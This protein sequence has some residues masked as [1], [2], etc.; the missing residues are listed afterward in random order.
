MTIATEILTVGDELLRGDVVDENSA[1]LATRL[2]QLGLAV[3]RC[4]SV[5]DPLEPLVRQLERA[6]GRCQL[7][8]VTGG[9]GPTD[10]DR[11]TEAV[12]R[13]GGLE[14]QLRE[15]VLEA[16]RERF[17]RAGYTLTANNEKQAWI[18][19]GATLL[20][21]S[22]GTAPGYM[23]RHGQ[24][25][26]VCLPGVPMELKKIF[27][28]HVAPLL[29]QQL[30][31]RP[32]L[33]RSLNTFG[34]GESQLDH[35]L[36]RLLDEVDHGDCEVSVHYRTSFPCNHLILVVRPAE[37]APAQAAS[38]V[39][40]RLEAAAREQVGKY[41]YGVDDTSFSDAVVAALREHGATLA[42][43]ESCTG[44]L[45]GDLITS[46]SGSSEVFELG[47]ITYSNEVK[48]KLLGVE[49]QIFEDHGA[50][51]QQCVEA[52]ARGVRRLAGADFGAA[53]SGIAGP[54]GGTQ[55]KPVGTVHFAVASAAGVRH[56]HRVFP[57]ERQR[58]KIVAAHT[59]L[60]LVMREL[61]KQ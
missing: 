13:L 39:L 41:V 48:H 16:M 2:G 19:A 49:R 4:V 11:T 54:T 12:G 6:A 40:D 42:L 56:L 38:S 27:D 8:V 47:A 31:C 7:L 57:F 43:A 1:W 46:A 37:G 24:C 35:R 17:R 55:E 28:A 21:N 15:D 45:T 53:I 3:R 59:A 14:L 36:G 30:E 22:W 9:L 20:E 50:V 18:P 23:V 33:V 25:R 60:A 52:M 44:G 29:Q 51:S 32:A 34:I 10:D 58:V 26:I 5:G 61:S